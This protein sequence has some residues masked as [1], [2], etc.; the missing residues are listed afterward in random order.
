MSMDSVDMTT[1]F[2]LILVCLVAVTRVNILI[3]CIVGISS[4]LIETGKDV[5]TV[6]DVIPF[7]GQLERLKMCE[8]LTHVQCDNF[9]M[10]MKVF[11]S[12]IC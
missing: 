6:I 7:T 10:S 11:P 5:P 9:F 2:A 1:I 8:K 4:P 12:F 3:E